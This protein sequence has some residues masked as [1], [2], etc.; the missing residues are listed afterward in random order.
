MIIEQIIYTATDRDAK[1]DLHGGYAVI[2]KT[3]GITED[4]VKFLDNYH[5]PIGILETED[6]KKKKYK[7][8][9]EFKEW[10]IYSTCICVEFSHDGRR[11]TLY[12]QHLVFKREDFKQINND[13]RPLDGFFVELP[14]SVRDED[15]VKFVIPY[16]PDN[17]LL[18]SDIPYNEKIVE[19]LKNKKKVAL[20]SKWTTD[21]Q[22]LLAL[23]E[24]EDRIIPW[25]NMMFEPM[26]QWD[27]KFILG[28]WFIEH[29]LADDKPKWLSF[30]MD[31]E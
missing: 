2:A 29:K 4:L 9:L 17:K 21:M 19:A 25:T 28:T 5:Y 15:L 6:L 7:S 10:L 18:K 22:E 1:H 24:P 27:F 12:T 20:I 23:M 8:L 13:T 26:R 14:H 16:A 31:P 30:K 3:T 11:G